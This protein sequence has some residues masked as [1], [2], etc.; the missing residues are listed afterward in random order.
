MAQDPCDSSKPF[1]DAS[2]PLNA[3]GLNALFGHLVFETDQGAVAGVE[4]TVS[5][6]LSIDVGTS[7]F[8]LIFRPT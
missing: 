2:I 4:S 5:K 3:A 1:A 6:W 8:R 7:V